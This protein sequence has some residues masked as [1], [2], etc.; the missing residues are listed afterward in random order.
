MSVAAVCDRSSV[1]AVC[2]R[3]SEHGG[4]WRALCEWCRIDLSASAGEVD[5]FAWQ[6]GGVGENG[7]ARA[8][9]A[10]RVDDTRSPLA[11]RTPLLRPDAH[12]TPH[13]ALWALLCARAALTAILVLL[14][15]VAD[16]IGGHPVRQQL[17][18]LH[19]QGLQHQRKQVELPLAS[20][21]LGYVPHKQL[22]HVL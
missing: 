22:V 10:Q 6:L 1:A 13:G 5:R 8:Q 11:Q 21:S 15:L 17:I 19:E 2:D 16:W 4:T 12:Q 9:R 14:L 18:V 3:S 7:G 20:T